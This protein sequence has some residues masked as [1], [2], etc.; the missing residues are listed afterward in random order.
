[1]K[2]TATLERKSMTADSGGKVADRW[3]DEDTQQHTE[4]GERTENTG[5]GAR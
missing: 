4:K 5:R 3:K 2:F 1:M